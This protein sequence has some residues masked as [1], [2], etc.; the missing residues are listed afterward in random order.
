MCVCV[1]VHC[2]GVRLKTVGV[3]ETEKIR[4]E[5]VGEGES[6]RRKRERE[7]PMSSHEMISWSF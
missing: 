7:S 6:K 4:E 3:R 5:K 1:F 2:T